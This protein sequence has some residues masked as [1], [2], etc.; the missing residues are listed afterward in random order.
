MGGW[1]PNG[2]GNRES[3]ERGMDYTKSS[4]RVQSDTVLELE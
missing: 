4:K 3:K 2:T 1:K